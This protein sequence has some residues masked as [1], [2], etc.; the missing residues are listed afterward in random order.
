MAA[1]DTISKV[2][3][4]GEDGLG[5]GENLL[6][7]NEPQGVCQA[8]EGRRIVMRGTHATTCHNVETGQSIIAGN[9]NKSQVIGIDVDIVAW[10]DRNCSLELAGQISIAIQRLGFATRDRLAVQPDLVIGTGFR[11]HMFA[12]TPRPGTGFTV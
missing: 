8:R 6:W 7:Q 11:Q 3:L 5:H 10:R 4:G 9:G 2:T 1:T 12:Q